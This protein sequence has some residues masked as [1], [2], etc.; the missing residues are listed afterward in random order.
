[1]IRKLPS[2]WNQARTSSFWKAMLH[3]GD[4]EMTS[5]SNRAE[6]LIIEEKSHSKSQ[7]IVNFSLEI[8]KI[9]SLRANSPL[10]FVKFPGSPGWSYHSF[11]SQ[12]VHFL[13]TCRSSL[14]LFKS[15]C[16]QCHVVDSLATKTGPT[17]NGLIGR[18]SGT[19]QGF[20]YSAANRSKVHGGRRG[21]V[22][23]E[24]CWRA[25]PRSVKITLI[26]SASYQ[27]IKILAVS[28]SERSVDARDTVRVPG[29]PEEVHSRHEDDLRRT[30]ESQR[31]RWPH[32]VRIYSRS[33]TRY[34]PKFLCDKPFKS[35][36]APPNDVLWITKTNWSAFTKVICRICRFLEEES[37][38]PATKWAH[39]YEIT[40][41]AVWGFW[42]PPSS[43]S[44]NHLLSSLLFSARDWR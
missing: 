43:T 24:K 17:L 25:D 42:R 20:D 11:C 21:L 10:L 15:R 39:D 26:G 29:R 19:V 8:K 16:E 41:R 44:S 12:T 30:Q 5:F 14:Q 28:I 9:P 35:I 37:K 3:L 2:S 38:K 4:L 31:T 40:R 13:E 34:F 32:Q 6:D 7:W 27:H 1:M 33:T 36:L 18:K 23:H 22:V